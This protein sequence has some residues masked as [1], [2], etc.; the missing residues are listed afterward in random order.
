M[1]WSAFL[2]ASCWTALA[3][4]YGWG[5]LRCGNGHWR[6][7]A[8]GKAPTENAPIYGLLALACGCSALLFWWLAV[9]QVGPSWVARFLNRTLGEMPLI[10]ALTAVAAIRRPWKG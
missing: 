9:G 10:L 8:A 1:D 2:V 7:R 4:V 6:W 3:A 5:W